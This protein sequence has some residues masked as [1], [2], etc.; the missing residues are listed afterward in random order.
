[1]SEVFD[2]ADGASAPQAETLVQ[3]RE[4][5]C[6]MYD[7]ILVKET[8]PVKFT[9]GGLEIPDDALKPL[10]EGYV[11]RTGKGRLMTNG[12]LIPL[13]VR[14]GDRVLFGEFSGSATKVNTPSGPLRVLREDEVLAWWRAEAIPTEEAQ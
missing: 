5:L 8:E 4:T 6:V 12:T 14:E 9:E 1:M 10:N 3:F 7:K 2:Q 13:N 11:V